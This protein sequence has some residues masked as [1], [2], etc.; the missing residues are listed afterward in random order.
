M[1]FATLDTAFLWSVDGYQSALDVAGSAPYDENGETES[2]PWYQLQSIGA[3]QS[4]SLRYELPP[5]GGMPTN[6]TSVD[7]LPDNQLDPNSVSSTGTSSS[8]SPQS[9][10]SARERRFPCP[11]RPCEARFASRN[12]LERHLGTRKH[13]KDE[14]NWSERANNYPCKVSAC[15]RKNKGF[16]RND[17]Y[18]N[19]L[20]RMH[21]GL[22]LDE[23]VYG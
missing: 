2:A 6:D 3:D 13:R 4:T 20:W 18:L 17:H 12:D 8:G 21:P 23:D 15:K 22:E 5:Y 9:Q 19:N 11:H 16:A 1:N 7:R 10:S 14:G